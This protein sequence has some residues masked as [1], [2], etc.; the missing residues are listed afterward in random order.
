MPMFRKK[1]VE[2]EAVQF[3]DTSDSI[4]EICELMRDIA[5]VRI[6]YAIPNEPKIPIDTLEGTMYASVGDYIIKDV[7]G[8]FYPCKPDIFAITYEP[9]ETQP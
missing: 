6:D 7:K 8:E 4:E 9:A 2:I 3:F 5:V 1:P